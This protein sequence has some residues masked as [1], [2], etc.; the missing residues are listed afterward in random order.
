MAPP[1]IIG[2][3]SE[4]E[5]LSLQEARAIQDIEAFTQNQMAE[6]EAEGFAS[7]AEAAASAEAAVAV[8]A[9]A[10]GSGI[11]ATAGEAA[12][13]VAG[14]SRWRGR[15]RR[16]WAPPV[17]AIEGGLNAASHVLGFAGG[18]GGGTDSDQSRSSGAVDIMTLNGTQ[19]SG[20]QQHFAMH[21]SQRQRPDEVIRIDSDSDSAPRAQ[22]APRVRARAARQQPSPFGLNP[23]PL[24]RPHGQSSGSEGSRISHQSRSDRGSLAAEPSFDQLRSDLELA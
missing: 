22:P 4:V 12:L 3:P 16:W 2:R 9:G 15:R 11:L 7:A 8:E 21:Q 17:W 14:A 5:P 13:G 23:I 19:E 6:A 20:V 18:G 10:A 24:P 1:Q